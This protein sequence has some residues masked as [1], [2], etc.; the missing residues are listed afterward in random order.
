[1]DAGSRPRTF[2]CWQE[3]NLLT[4]DGCVIVEHSHLDDLAEQISLS[5]AT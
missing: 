1:M 5:A 4:P 3:R 2:F